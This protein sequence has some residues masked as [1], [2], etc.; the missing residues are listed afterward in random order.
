MGYVLGLDLGTSALKALLV[1][2]K[3]IVIANESSQYPTFSKEAGFN[4]QDPNDWLLACDNVFSKLTRKVVDFQEKLVGLSF[5]GQ[6]HSLVLLDEQNQVLRPAILWNDVRT[7][8]Q[9]A[10]IMAKASFEL[11]KVTKNQALE[12]FTLPKI[13]WVMA[14]EPEIWAKVAHILLP[15]DY[16]R[17]YLTG[18]LATDYSDAAGTLLLDVTTKQWSQTL[19]DIFEIPVCKLPPLVNSFARTDELRPEIRQKYQLKKEVA[20]FAGAA[21]N[22]CAAVGSGLHSTDTALVSI[23]T[24]GVFLAIEPDTTVDYQGKLHFFNH[25][26]PNEYYAMGVTLSAGASLNWF[27][28]TFAPDQSF[29][30][31]LAKIKT[32]A[33]GSDGL[34]F[35]PYL[36][37]E[38][39]PYF[40]SHVRGSFIGIDN[41]HDFAHFVRAVVEGITFS[42][43]DSQ[44]LLTTVGK[45]RFQRIISVGGGAKNKT[46]LQIQ[47]DIFNTPV[48]S[49]ISEQGPSLG[50]AMIAAL[51]LGWFD[52][53]QD[54]IK[55]FVKYSEVIYPNE[56]NVLR[57]DVIYEKYRQIYPNNV[58]FFH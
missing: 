54:C 47:A 19:L 15:K 17:W 48:V 22:A 46:W 32:V 25:A 55:I 28:K 7:T 31:L 18:R 45:R 51:G 44:T 36:S 38:R 40:D 50:A 30:T 34:F 2:E 11:L 43:R 27:K 3:G 8:K 9:C 12:G 56:S 41:R 21:D 37:G 4:E 42:L 1:D 57:Y 26:Y 13:R 5:S 35:T 29:E 49:L 53:I 14:N 23:G 33:P 10:E 39:T 52:S 20:V 24:S 58:E 6:M 16:L